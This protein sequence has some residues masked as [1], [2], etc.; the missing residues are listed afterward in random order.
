MSGSGFRV[1]QM[2]SQTRRV[3][4][5]DVRSCR[6]RWRVGVTLCLLPV[7][8]VFRAPPRPRAPEKAGTQRAI[9]A[10]LHT[11]HH[12]QRVAK[13]SFAAGGRDGRDAGQWVSSPGLRQCPLCRSRAVSFTELLTMVIPRLT[14]TIVSWN[15]GLLN[16]LAK[17]SEHD[18]DVTIVT[19]SNQ[20]REKPVSID[21][22]RDAC[23]DCGWTVGRSCSLEG[24]LVGHVISDS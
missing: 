3:P 20:S 8:P 18:Q 1:V 22:V 16:W 2:Y 21:R 14:R 24:N 19:C 5:S 4:S 6:P 10:T 23:G 15:C 7:G 12:L 9:L 13:C 11:K 17:N